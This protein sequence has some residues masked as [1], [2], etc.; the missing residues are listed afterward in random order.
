MDNGDFIKMEEQALMEYF[1]FDDADLAVNRVG[2]LTEKQK[3]RLTAELKSNGRG[4][5]LLSLFMF[6]IALVGVGGAVLIWVTDSSWVMRII[7]SI[8]FGLVW[9][10]LYGLM[11]FAFWPSDKSSS[12]ELDQVTGRVNIV[13]VEHRNSETGGTSSRYDLYIGARRFLADY[14][15][16]GVMVNGDEYT[17]YFLKY[18]NKIVS[19]EL[20]SKTR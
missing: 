19:A 5:I 7:F 16:G 18:S 13:R 1:K 15:V 6:F 12:L 8:G 17:V 14:K 10:A 4:R 20:N 2:S 3:V 11:G 9:P